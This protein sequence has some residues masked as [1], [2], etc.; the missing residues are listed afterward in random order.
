MLLFLLESGG[1]TITQ[2]LAKEMCFTQ[3]KDLAR[4]VA[5][6]M[7]AFDLEKVYSKDEILELYI[8]KIYYGDG[9]YGLKEASLGYYKKMPSELT[10]SELTTLAG[11]PNA[12]SIYS[13]T[14]SPRLAK[15]R[16]KQVLYAM[17]E[18]GYMSQETMN[19]IIN[20]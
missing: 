6:I 1:S 18:Y 17:V 4:K 9:Y 5:E 16:Q 11:I 14:N 19:E 8:N 7:V 10:L 2:Q 12:P 13:L 20:E 15:E 3:D